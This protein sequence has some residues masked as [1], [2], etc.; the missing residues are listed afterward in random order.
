MNPKIKIQGRKTSKKANRKMDLKWER[1]L[2]NRVLGPRPTFS[3]QHPEDE[4]TN[5]DLNE[6]VELSETSDDEIKIRMPESDEACEKETNAKPKEVVPDQSDITENSERELKVKEDQ[7][8]CKECKLRFENKN[9]LRGHIYK[10]HEGEE[11]KGALI[12]LIAKEDKLNNEPENLIVINTDE[13]KKVKDKVPYKCSICDQQ[14]EDKTSVDVLC[15]ER[16]MYH[17][18]CV[19]NTICPF[20]E[21]M[22]SDVLDNFDN[23]KPF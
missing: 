16:M 3:I 21:R 2:V 14:K 7:Y 1:D 11:M 5:E 22:L 6:L 8:E 20:R 4:A 18:Y 10:T 15:P 12:A 23:R 19:L 9:Y 17:S 13:E